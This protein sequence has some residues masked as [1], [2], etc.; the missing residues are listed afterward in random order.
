MTFTSKLGH[1]GG[2]YCIG[3]VLSVVEEYKIVV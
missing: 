2:S 3:G 1:I